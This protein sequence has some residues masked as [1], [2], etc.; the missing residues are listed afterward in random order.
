MKAKDSN[1]HKKSSSMAARTKLI[2]LIFS[3]FYVPIMRLISEV[4]ASLIR[5]YGQTYLSWPET[6]VD[7]VNR[8][9]L[10]LTVCST[11]LEIVLNTIKLIKLLLP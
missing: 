1:R 5:L 8:A 11:I 2:A 6:V 10:I 4:A 7:K 3:G 9:L